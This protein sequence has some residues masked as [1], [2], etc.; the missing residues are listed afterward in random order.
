MVRT[1][2]EKDCIDDS[3]MEPEEREENRTLKI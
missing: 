3:I 2:N 1:T